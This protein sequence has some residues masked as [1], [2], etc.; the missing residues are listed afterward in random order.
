MEEKGLNQM[1]NQKRSR[2]GKIGTKA[3]KVFDKRRQIFPRNV[4]VNDNNLEKRKTPI[5]KMEKLKL[6]NK[7]KIKSNRNF[8]KTETNVVEELI[9]ENKIKNIMRVD[10]FMI[11]EYEKSESIRSAHAEDLPNENYK[12]QEIPR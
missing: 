7:S 11:Y 5:L 9:E 1:T 10:D 6:N 12:N 4:N 3:R 2:A 8:Q